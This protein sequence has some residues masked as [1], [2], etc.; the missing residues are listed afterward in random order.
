MNRN[1]TLWYKLKINLNKVEFSGNFSELEVWWCSLGA[2][3]GDEEDGKNVLFERPVLVF[4][5]YNKS[6]FFALPLS[7]ASKMSKFYHEISVG[8]EN[9]IVLV[10]QGRVISSR[11]LQRRIGKITSHE[12]TSIAKKY[13]DLHHIKSSSQL[14]GNS[15][16]PNGDLYS[17]ITKHEQKSQ[18][19]K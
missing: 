1:Y 3:I 18:E 10:S 8:D 16:A 2:N 13:A 15:Q 6:L 14:L 11:R 19:R 5:K 17:N 7:T 4:R 9:G 12:F